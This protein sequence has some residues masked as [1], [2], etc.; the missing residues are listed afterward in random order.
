MYADVG[1]FAEE[2]LVSCL[3]TEITEQRSVIVLIVTISTRRRSRNSDVVESGSWA[4][5]Q[6]AVVN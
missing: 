1:M 6:P 3:L 4:G 5:G 2:T